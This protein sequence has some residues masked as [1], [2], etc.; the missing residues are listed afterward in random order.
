MGIIL[1]SSA[2][3]DLLKD[4]E[5][6]TGEENAEKIVHVYG[7]AMRQ[8][9]TPPTN[10]QR[11]PVAPRRYEPLPVIYRH[12]KRCLLHLVPEQKEEI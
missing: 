3:I 6:K 7:P 12:G 5:I 9:Y 2:P 10:T 1:V 4:Y 11:L 8:P